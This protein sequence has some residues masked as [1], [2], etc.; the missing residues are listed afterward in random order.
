RCVVERI[1]RY[2]RYTISRYSRTGALARCCQ[3]PPAPDAPH[4]GAAPARTAPAVRGG[5]AGLAG[6]G[7]GLALARAL[8]VD[9]WRHQVL[10]EP[11][12]AGPLQQRLVLDRR[13]D[14]LDPRYR[15]GDDRR[16]GRGRWCPARSG[17]RR[18]DY[19]AAERA[20]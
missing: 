7:E 10:A 12:R 14:R 8:A 15:A 9:G 16:A 6:S 20:R 3:P 19:L 11:Q 17:R 2:D 4:R 18:L 13:S 5:Q 1:I